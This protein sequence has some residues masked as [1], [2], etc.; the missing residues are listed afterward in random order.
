MPDARK[1]LIGFFRYALTLILNFDRGS[2]PA[3]ARQE[4]R[5]T[6]SF[7]EE[8]EESLNKYQESL[9]KNYLS[10]TALILNF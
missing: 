2:G 1:R 7:S 4:A 8:W 5:A 9:L 3:R 10:Q 6:P